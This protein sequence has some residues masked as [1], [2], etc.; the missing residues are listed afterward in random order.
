MRR[1]KSNCKLAKL[2]RG[3]LG[4]GEDDN[5]G[6]DLSNLSGSLPPPP[7]PP[8]D[9]SPQLESSESLPT[10]DLTET[11]PD[12]QLEPSESSPTSDIP[13]TQP[14]LSGSPTTTDITETEP[15]FSGTPPPSTTDVVEPSSSDLSDNLPLNSQPTNSATLYPGT[16]LTDIE[17]LSKIILTDNDLSDPN[18]VF[19]PSVLGD[20]DPVSS[21]SY[22]YH[23]TN[24]T[25]ITRSFDPD[26]EK[27]RK[28]LITEVPE[29]PLEG[30]ILSTDFSTTLQD[31]QRLLETIKDT[32]PEYMEV[33]YN[34][35]TYIISKNNPYIIVE[36]TEEEKTETQDQAMDIAKQSFTPATSPEVS[37]SNEL[38]L[39]SEVQ[40][41]LKTEDNIPPPSLQ[42][43]S[44]LDDEE[45]STSIS[46]IPGYENTSPVESIL[47]SSLPP[48]SP[49]EQSQSQTQ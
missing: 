33:V 26:N 11:E 8:S 9:L 39:P 36:K 18:E 41:P 2:M 21:N 45:E 12:L 27:I 49:L 46:P 25:G 47:P 35:K 24:D 23:G 32:L 43:T 30:N 15:D 34:D 37:P 17:G 1:Q 10:S 6:A 4:E 44:V 7:P 3:G 19:D 14:D 48:P 22:I 38:E 28:V 5:T 16:T 13:A 42:S 40:E 29:S 20:Q 31:I